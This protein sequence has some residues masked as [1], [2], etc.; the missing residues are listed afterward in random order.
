[1][2][3]TDWN[4]EGPQSNPLNNVLLADTGPADDNN[5]HRLTAFVSTSIAA[6][7]DLELRDSTNTITLKSLPIFVLAGT[8]QSIPLTNEFFVNVNERI[9]LVLIGAIIGTI[10]GSLFVQ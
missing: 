2:P 9:R 5:Q 8:S 6:R 7:V 4:T 1:M 3:F 10:S